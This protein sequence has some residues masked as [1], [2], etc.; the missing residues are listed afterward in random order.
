VESVFR[1]LNDRERGLNEKLLEADFQG[2]DELRAQIGSVT[3]K[4]IEDDGTLELRC[5]SGP[6]APTKYAVAME[7][8]Y[9]DADGAMV[10]IML[11]VGK[12]GFMRMLEILRYDGLPIITPPVAEGVKVY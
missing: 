8:V 7:G 5:A 1:Q 2:R 10:A 6:P 12:D 9:I 3:A 4:E 11:H